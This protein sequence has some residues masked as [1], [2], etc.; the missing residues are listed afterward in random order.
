L[1]RVHMPCALVTGVIAW[2]AV[3]VVRPVRRPAP[4][5]S[6]WNEVSAGAATPVVKLRI[7][8]EKLESLYHR[9]SPWIS[10]YRVQN[11]S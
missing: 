5:P 3:A 4:L 7:F 11:V 8:I 2:D 1:P 9:D 10:G 6:T